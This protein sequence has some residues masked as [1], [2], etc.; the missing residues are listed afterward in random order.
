[1]PLV[2]IDLFKMTLKKS[3]EEPHM[4]IV[5]YEGKIEPKISNEKHVNFV[6]YFVNDRHDHQ[7]MLH[8]QPKIS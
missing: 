4:N 5:I 8:K 2:W 6:L 1:M 3:P 7:C